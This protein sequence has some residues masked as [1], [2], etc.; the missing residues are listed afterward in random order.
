MAFLTYSFDKGKPDPFEYLPVTTSGSPAVNETIV[1]GEVLKLSSGK[2]TKA[3]VDSDNNNGEYIAMQD[4]ADV[5][6]GGKI[7]CVRINA[8][9][10]YETELSAAYSAIAA[11]AKVTLDSTA[12]KVT[13]TTTKG[14]A[15]IIDWDGKAVGD[16][17]RVRLK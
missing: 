1:I 15:E 3:G 11:G 13:A 5:P 9:T 6:V 17:V 12:T 4:S 14:I 7:A 16:K 10:V 8:D 2:L